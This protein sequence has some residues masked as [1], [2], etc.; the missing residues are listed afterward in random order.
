MPPFRLNWD[1]YADSERSSELERVS[2]FSSG[3]ARPVARFPGAFE[4]VVTL[5]GEVGLGRKLSPVIA[6]QDVSKIEYRENRFRQCRQSSYLLFDMTW[7]QPLET[8]QP[9]SHEED[10]QVP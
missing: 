9:A 2:R 10:A 4:S 6:Q 5:N 1:L 8:C 7:A 3:L